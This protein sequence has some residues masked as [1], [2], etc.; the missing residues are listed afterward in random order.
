MKATSLLKLGA[1]IAGIA[2]FRANYDVKIDIIQKCSKKRAEESA[3]ITEE[4]SKWFEEG[5]KSFESARKTDKNPYLPFDFDEKTRT[6]PKSQD[7]I[8]AEL[9]QKVQEAGR[10]AAK[11]LKWELENCC[12]AGL[13]YSSDFPGEFEQC[14]GEVCDGW[15]D[16]WNGIPGYSD[17][18]R[19]EAVRASLKHEEPK[20]D[21][22]I[23]SEAAQDDEKIKKLSNRFKKRPSYFSN[24]QPINF[25][26]NS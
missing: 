7:E 2:W 22:E 14:A 11:K 20:E 9:T 8:N 19:E 24:L 16:E 3:K 13:R 25:E 12:C 26:E 4:I 21:G 17:K 1:S 15:I 18:L 6:K 23:T 5:V 10:D